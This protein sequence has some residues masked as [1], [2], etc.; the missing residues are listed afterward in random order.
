MAIQNF[1]PLV[2][3]ST[4]LEAFNSC[5]IRAFRNYIQHLQSEE[6]IDLVA[7]KAFAHGAHVARDAFYAQGLPADEAVSLGIEALR[8]SYGDFY[9]PWKPAKS[10]DRMA[11]A[12][13]SYF[14][15]YDMRFDEVRPLKLENGNYSIEYSLLSPILDL[16]GN[17]ILHPTLK[18]PLLFSGRLD[19]LA[20]YIGGIYIVDEKTT[21]SYFTKN[22]SQ[23]WETRG[24]FTGYKWLAQQS[25]IPELANINGAI[26][27]G[28]CLPSSAAT[29]EDTKNKFYGNIETIKHTECLT[30]RSQYEVDNWH[31]DMV[32]TIQRM[33]KKYTMYMQ[34][35]KEPELFFSGS[36]GSACTGYGRGCQ[37]IEHC[38]SRHGEKFLE[39]A[40]EQYIWRPEKHERQLLSEYLAELTA[41]QE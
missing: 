14:D 21:G 2:W 34:D 1:F 24:Q 16:E 17:P 10:I 7:G 5:E 28:I 6:S 27:R 37:F 20:E 41:M 9:D 8:E 11:L 12:L 35:E 38:K 18:L 13:E 40:Y 4:Q 3:D 39:T 33:V 25:G 23:Q 29:S 30:T 22:W 15:E 32:S 19:L 31:R 36:W 26:V